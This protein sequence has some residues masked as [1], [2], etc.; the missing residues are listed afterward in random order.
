M[1]R[2]M[3]SGISGMKVNQTKLDV[4]GNNIANVSTTA[5]TSS[6]AE[7]KDMLYQ[8]AGNASQPTTVMGGTNAKQIGLGTQISSI[9]KVMTHGHVLTTNRSLDVAIDKDGYF[10]VGK[11]I[12]D[13]DNG[14]NEVDPENHNFTSDAGSLTGSNAGIM[15]ILYTRD[16]NFTLD[17][18][19]NLLTADGYRIMGYVLTDGTNESIT[20]PTTDDGNVLGAAHYVDPD[21]D[22]LKAVDVDNNPKLQPLIIPESIDSIPVTGFD[23]GKDGII[24]AKLGDGRRSALGQ[25]A[26]ATFKNPEGLT[27]VGGNLYEVSSNS[28]REVIKSG[29]GCETDNDNSQGFG[30]MVQYALEGSNVDLTEQFTDMIVATRAFQ[31]SSKM[32]NTGDEILQTITNLIR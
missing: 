30:S 32:I 22:Q 2:C 9:N 31:A 1:L 13:Y 20:A 10:I 7:F 3:N 18:Q 19:G 24:I 25:I 29:K 23:I 16:G 12:V 17:C 4:I 21:S 11:G 26:M 5:F 14:G 8:N 28:G 27:N 6:R 15:N